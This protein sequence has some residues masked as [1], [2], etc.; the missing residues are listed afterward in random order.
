LFPLWKT[1]EP[2]SFALEAGH[3]MQIQAGERLRLTLWGAG[4]RAMVSLNTYGVTQ[5]ALI[6]TDPAEDG[7]TYDVTSWLH[8]GSNTLTL[9]LMGE[10]GEAPFRMIV[11][12]DGQPDWTLDEADFLPLGTPWRLWTMSIE[13]EA[14]RVSVPACEQAPETFQI[15]VGG[16]PPGPLGLGRSL[17]TDQSM[18]PASFISMATPDQPVRAT[19]V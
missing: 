1:P 7:F 5:P 14:P 11:S 4:C 10:A 8:D 2:V 9:V 3:I 6:G 15:I 17:R 19:S 12:Q 13:R 18:A 16:R